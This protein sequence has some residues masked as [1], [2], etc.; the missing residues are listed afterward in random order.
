MTVRRAFWILIALCSLALAGCNSGGQ[1]V[2]ATPIQTR[3]RVVNLVPNA[4]AMMLTLDNTPVVT[5]LAFQQLSG[6]LNVDSGTHEFKVS[7]DG[8]VTNIIDVS[9]TITDRTDNTFIVNGPVEA[10]QS[11][12]LLDTQLLLPDAGTFQI[13][14]INLAPG[15]PLVD[16]YLTA[17][18]V[19]L[20]A[21]GPTVSGVTYGSTGAFI[22]V[23]TASYELRVTPTGLK[24]VIFDTGAVSFGDRTFSEAIIYGR[25]STRLVD[26]AVLNIDP[27]GTGQAYQNLLAEFKLLNASSVGSPL[28]VFVDGNPALAN[29]PFA[30]VSSYQIT[31]AGAHDITVEATAT[32]G[33]NVLSIPT[34]LASA[35]DTS[36]VVS[37]PAGA[38]QALVLSDNNLPAAAGHARIR[39]INAS[40]DL[41]A[42]DV[43]VDFVRQFAN[44]ASNSA[45][46]Y[47]EIQAD[48]TGTTT[49][50]FDFNLAGTTSPVLRLP[51]VVVTSG[52]TYSVYVV[53][54]G[55]ALQG[56]VVAD[57]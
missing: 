20:A 56:V 9:N 57:N 43:Y 32:P 36:I 29:V 22:P 13:R 17:P 41:A 45:S 18:G 7:V 54:P 42:F 23:N 21:T 38:L 40:P 50:E 24:Q 11:L 8:G 4:G 34:T 51:G 28:N 25:G 14:M 55:T 30:G 6:Y 27:Q 1:G 10:A 33:A 5:G 12:L 39:F 37:G 35:S 19:D 48:A 44:V 16:V 49:H 31:S 46:P 52:R 47:T 26:V 2:G 3:I 15:A 53:G